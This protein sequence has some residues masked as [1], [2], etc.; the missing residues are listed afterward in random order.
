VKP[1]KEGILGVEPWSLA[2]EKPE[3]FKK[4]VA[5]WVKKYAMGD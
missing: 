1:S 4:T 3:E 5:E 2:E